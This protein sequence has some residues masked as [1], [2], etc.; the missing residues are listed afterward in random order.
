M[1]VQLL[2]TEVQDSYIRTRVQGD[3]RPVHVAQPVI[4][5][6]LKDK[7]CFNCEKQSLLAEN[8]LE[9]KKCS[10]CGGKGRL[11]SFC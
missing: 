2:K 1:T 7:T 3:L 6:N 11:A 8:C 9:S 5:A 4:K 10:H